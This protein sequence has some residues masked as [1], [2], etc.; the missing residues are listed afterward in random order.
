MTTILASDIINKE[1]IKSF[2]YVIG[3]I[4]SFFEH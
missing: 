3:L 2:Y 1:L 4:F